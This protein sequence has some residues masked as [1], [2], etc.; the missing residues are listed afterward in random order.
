MEIDLAYEAYI[1]AER[2]WNAIGVRYYAA[3]K[4]T[5]KAYN[6]YR[7]LRFPEDTPEARP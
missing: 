4:E 5:Q 7:V 2:R 6:A 3:M 1:E